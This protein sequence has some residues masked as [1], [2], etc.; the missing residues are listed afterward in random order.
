LTKNNDF[1]EKKILN[2]IKPEGIYNKPEPKIEWNNKTEQSYIDNGFTEI[3]ANKLT[4]LDFL[5]KDF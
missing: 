3:L 5:E 2:T 1:P 4:P